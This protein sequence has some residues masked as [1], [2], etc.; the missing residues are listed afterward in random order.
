MSPT[1]RATATAQRPQ[2]ILDAAL[3]CFVQQGV[4]EATLATIRARAHVSTGS[5][6]HH[7]SSKDHLATALYIEGLR[8]A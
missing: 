4:T 2:A 6:Y 3:A 5:R 1:P 7:F 8:Q